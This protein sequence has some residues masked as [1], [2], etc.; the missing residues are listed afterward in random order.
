VTAPLDPEPSSLPA[1]FLA[2]IPRWSA[3]RWHIWLMVGL[4]VLLVPVTLIWP[5]LLPLSWQLALGNHTNVISATGASIAA[6]AGVATHHE[7]RRRRQVE[8]HRHAATLATHQLIT[9][10]H[11]HHLGETE[12]TQT[13]G[14][15]P[16]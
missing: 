15:E 9:E 3:S 16:E 4:W 7:T 10:L 13:P 14:T 5:H 6:G 8:E 12:D 1:R 2:A 11:A